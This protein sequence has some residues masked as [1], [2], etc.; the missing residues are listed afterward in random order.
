MHF[1]KKKISNIERR[2]I[3]LKS[4]KGANKASMVVHLWK[5]HCFHDEYMHSRYLGKKCCQNRGF[6]EKF[7][8]VGFL[9]RRVFMVFCCNSGGVSVSC[10]CTSQHQENTCKPCTEMRMQA[11]DNSLAP[12]FGICLAIG[13]HVAELFLGCCNSHVH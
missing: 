6:D 5:N 9:I 12:H 10:A 4:N 1:G 11:K 7:V 13:R 2:C 3:H 8:P